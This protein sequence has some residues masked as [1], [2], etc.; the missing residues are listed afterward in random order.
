MT[1][2][3]LISLKKKLATLS[4][5][6][7][8]K[9][10]LYLRKV[11]NGEI[12]GAMTGYPSVDRPWLKYYPE[13]LI[14]KDASD[15]G[16]YEFLQ[17]QN[18]N[19]NLIAINY[20]GRKYTY[21]ELFRRIDN[22]AKAF[23]EMGIHEGDVVTLLLANTPENV[24]SIYALNKIGAIPNIVDLRQKDDKLVHSIR[25]ADSKM[26]LATDL[27][28]K[29]LDDVADQ[30]GDNRIVVT[31]PFDSMPMPLEGIL[32][33][34][35]K[36]YKPKNFSFVKWKDF[37]KMGSQSAL[38]TPHHPKPDDPACIVHTSGT[39]GDA[40]GVLLTNK[41]FNTMFLEY[42]KII[43]DSRPG[44]KVLCHVPP[45]LAYSAIMAIHVP[46]S[47]G[48]TLQMLPYYQPEKF[49]ANIAK[50]KIQHAVAG[51]A[52][53]Y[54]IL[55][56]PKVPKRDYSNLIS[57]GSGSDKIDTLKRHEIDQRLHDA[58]CRHHIFEGYGMTEVGSA[59]V[60]NLPYHIVDDSVGVPLCKMNVMI[61]DNENDC[62]LPYG[63]VGEI[64]FSGGTMMKEYFKNPEATEHTIR[65]HDGKYWVHSGD[66]GYMNPDGN[67]FLKGRIKRIIIRHD[68]I[69]ISPLDLENVI[70]AS[71]LVDNCCVVG[72]PDLEHGRGSIPIANIVEKEDSSMSEEELIQKI[73]DA[74]KKGLGDNYLPKKVVIRES[75]PLTPVGKVDYRSL[76]KTCS[77]EQEAKVFRK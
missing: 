39:T 16:I 53:W 47:M 35:K 74:C 64:C 63:E 36:Q 70:M 72:V 31:S 51:P 50:Y 59:A 44:D 11:S 45:F 4:E 32:K 15:L 41:N 34:S 37:E 27:F 2:E 61:Y 38:E 67:I 20:F 7:E 42:D 22:T 49:A 69:K 68:G 26:I 65:L 55:S 60:T 12:A 58:G 46:L 17:S 10:N 76:E 19:R 62:E 21:E 6:E 24:I 66:L 8:K 77:E 33:L 48:V 3:E 52:D 54:N 23:M 56:D 30:I 14:M 29:N 43:V 25:S 1:K 57:M 28:L 40:K 5:M 71:G 18:K 13:E 73:H 75:L 9:R